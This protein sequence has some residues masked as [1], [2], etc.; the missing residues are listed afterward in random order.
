MRIVLPLTSF[1]SIRPRVDTRMKKRFLLS[2]VLLASLSG[3]ISFIS[4]ASAEQNHIPTVTRLVQIFSGLENDLS[5][6]LRKG[7]PNAIDQLLADDF[8][9]RAGSMPGSPTPRA[10]WIS[11]MKFSGPPLTIRQMS[12]HDHGNVAAVSFIW[13]KG[14][15]A[16]G[17]TA[18]N[19]FIVDVWKKS[20][21]SWKLATRYASPAGNPRIAIPGTASDTPIEKRY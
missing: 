10:E 4:P 2:F 8:E 21:A 14:A 6:S 19:I 16:K 3:G 12:V 20:D 7:D 9:M 13:A 11:S 5:E 17:K 1:S 15:T 18:G